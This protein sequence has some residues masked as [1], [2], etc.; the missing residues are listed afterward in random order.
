MTVKDCGPGFGEGRFSRSLRFSRWSQAVEV[1]QGRGSDDV[2]VWT[3]AD[4]NKH[5]YEMGTSG[6]HRTGIKLPASALT[7][8]RSP[9]P[10]TARSLYVSFSARKCCFL[11][12]DQRA[13]G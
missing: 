12:A 7:T 1:P 4:F 9:D 13:R 5:A 11:L 8:N 3:V 6:L 10:G 2:V